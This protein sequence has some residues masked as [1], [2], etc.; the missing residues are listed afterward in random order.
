MGHMNAGMPYLFRND[1][2]R[3]ISKKILYENKDAGALHNTGKK[4]QRGLNTGSMG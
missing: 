4:E 1:A 2:E 3:K